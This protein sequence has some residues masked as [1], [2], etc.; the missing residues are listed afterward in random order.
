LQKDVQTE[1]RHRAERAAN[2]HKEIR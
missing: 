2:G 1:P